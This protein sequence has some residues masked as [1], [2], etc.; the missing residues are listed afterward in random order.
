MKE[1]IL[2]IIKDGGLFCG[3]FVR[4]YLIRGEDYN[5]I[6]FYFS[7]EMPE[8]YVSW[9]FIGGAKTKFFEG[10]KFHCGTSPYDITCNVFSF[11][12]EKIVARP[13]Y[14]EFSY[15]RSWEM[16]FKKEFVFTTMKDI[17]S[18]EKMKRR[19]WIKVE[20]DL[21]KRKKPFAPQEGIWLDF[22]LA[23]ER[24]DKLINK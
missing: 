18:A 11:D 21:R 20:S 22:T 15:T 14:M 2:K 16:I 12:G 23:K 17:S 8:P 10:T 9:P 1:Q 19:G 7:S 5:D 24:F 6:D 3:G 13:T 4:D